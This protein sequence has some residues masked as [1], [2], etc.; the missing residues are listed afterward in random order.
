M[1]FHSCDVVDQ[2]IF[3]LF[4]FKTKFIQNISIFA[5]FSFIDFSY[6][7]HGFSWFCFSVLVGYF[8]NFFPA[9]KL[10]IFTVFY[11]PGGSLSWTSL[12]LFYCYKNHNLCVSWLVL[13]KLYPTFTFSNFKSHPLFSV[14]GS[15]TNSFVYF[16]VLIPPL[17][18]NRKKKQPDMTLLS[19]RKDILSL[20]SCYWWSRDYQQA[21]L[22]I[23]ATRFYSLMWSTPLCFFILYK[24]IVFSKR[25]G[26]FYPSNLIYQ[27]WRDEA[28]CFFCFL[29]FFHVASLKCLPFVYIGFFFVTAYICIYDIC[30]LK[31]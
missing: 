22:I 14:K 26:V 23:W 7:F 12:L 30:W 18:V 25:N 6:F 31:S 10:G 27:F 2:L 17:K 21:C 4:F 1:A 24:Q 8:I 19:K 20:L 15:R 3:S 5:L 9:G 11:F 13:R 28:S 16:N 29:S